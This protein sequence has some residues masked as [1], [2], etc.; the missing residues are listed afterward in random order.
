MP[1]DDPPS[2]VTEDVGRS[3]R[4]GWSRAFARLFAALMGIAF[5]A[6]VV[7]GVV[8][9]QEGAKRPEWAQLFGKCEICHS[10]DPGRHG[11]GPS[12]HCVIGRKLASYED[13][14]YSDEMQALGSNGVWDRE[15]LKRY[16]ETPHQMIEGTRMPF[17]GISGED[18]NLDV[19]VDHIVSHCEKSHDLVLIHRGVKNQLNGCTIIGSMDLESC[20]RVADQLNASNHRSGKGPVLICR[21]EGDLRC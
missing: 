17:P 20:S 19:L 3:R 7:E 12:L 16:I 2:E 5:L 9:L 18:N 13:Y 8:I 21:P 14:R 15:L 10:L 4:T 1:S 6:T 11:V